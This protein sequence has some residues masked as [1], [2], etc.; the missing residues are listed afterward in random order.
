MKGSFE[1][2]ANKKKQL[3]EAQY[4]AFKLEIDYQGQ[5]KTLQDQLEKYHKE[6][7][8]ERICSK[9]LEVTFAQHQSDIDKRFEEIRSLNGE[10]HRNLE[11]RNQ[12]KEEAI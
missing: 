2:I 3:A 6:L 4:Q 7:K 11:E 9:K 10:E 5:L 1:T 8:E 12:L